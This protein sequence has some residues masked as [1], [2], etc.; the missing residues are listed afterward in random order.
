MTIGTP[1]QPVIWQGA[2]PHGRQ[3][4][5]RGL[6]VFGNVGC[7]VTSVAMALR[8]LGV[9]AGA[10]PLDVQAAG[11]RRPGVWAPGSSGCNVPELVRAQDGLTVGEDMDGAGKVASV[12]RI[13]PLILDCLTR[14][15]VVLA[16]VDYDAAS[17]KGDPLGDH[18]VTIHGLEGDDLLLADPATARTERLLC[19]T[20]AGPVRWGEKVRPYRVTRAITV[21]RS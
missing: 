5:G 14:G 18:W 13:A 20:L 10:M 3:P 16:A 6:E 21:F 7:V 9:R 8:H 17:P 1:P 19:P 15:G 2:R 11:L 4:V 12:D